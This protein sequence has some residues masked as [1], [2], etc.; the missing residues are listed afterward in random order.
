MF[1]AIVP[2]MNEAETIGR[3]VRALDRFCDLVVVVD[4]SDTATTRESAKAAGAD[5]ASHILPGSLGRAYSYGWGYIPRDWY[6]GHID[7][8][9]SHDPADLCDMLDMAAHDDIDLLLGD[10]FGIGGEHRGKWHRKVTSRLASAALN[11][12][13]FAD[14][15]DW[16]SGLRVYSPK[17]RE[18]LSRHDFTTSGHAWQI[19][20][21]WVCR[22]AGLKIAEYPIIYKASPS[23]LSSSRVREAGGLWWRLLWE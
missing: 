7:A 9:G 2:T 16:T 20:A 3:L 23:H 11:L 21:L 17:A 4:S 12:I 22:Q 18:I 14:Y 6:V 10:R 19:E 8:G 5:Y 13:S 1:A 15:D